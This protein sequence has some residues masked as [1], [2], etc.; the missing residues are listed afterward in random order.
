MPDDLSVPIVHD[1]DQVHVH[2]A[3][4]EHHMDPAVCRIAVHTLDLEGRGV[5]SL[6]IACWYG[7]EVVTEWK[8]SRSSGCTSV[9]G[10]AHR[11]PEVFLGEQR[12]RFSLPA[13]AWAAPIVAPNFRQIVAARLFGL[14]R[15]QKSRDG[16]PSWQWV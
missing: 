8:G 4:V 12:H 11:R 2:Q 14:H 9:M 5:V 10:G 16:P 1:N 15:R 13:P 3:R 6:E 7:P